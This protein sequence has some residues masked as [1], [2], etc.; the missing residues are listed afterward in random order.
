MGE[1][2]RQRTSETKA[3]WDRERDLLHAHQQYMVNLLLA[4]V[5]AE[6][7][8]VTLIVRRSILSQ[9]HENAA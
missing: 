1:W 6:G 9:S 2:G 7:V 5:V 3:V 8:G 4:A